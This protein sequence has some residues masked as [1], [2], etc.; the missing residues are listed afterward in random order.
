MVMMMNQILQITED[1][2][3]AKG[4]TKYMTWLSKSVLEKAVK[5]S[6]VCFHK[7]LLDVTNHLKGALF[8]VRYKYYNQ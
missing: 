3:L 8:Q 6:K 1:F 5:F 7:R 2:V 4:L